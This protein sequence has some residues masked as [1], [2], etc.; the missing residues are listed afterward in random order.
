MAT[1]KT[2]TL[3]FRIDPGLSTVERG[4]G[5]EITPFTHLLPYFQP[6]VHCKGKQQG[7]GMQRAMALPRKG[8]LFPN[9]YCGTR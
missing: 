2:A 5:S 1:V 7:N 4:I 8:R 6:P 3:T 9:R